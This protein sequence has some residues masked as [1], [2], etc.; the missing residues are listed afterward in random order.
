MCYSG[1][2]YVSSY[3]QQ[4]LLHLRMIERGGAKA[5]RVAAVVAT[6]VVVQKIWL[7]IGSV[8]DNGRPMGISIYV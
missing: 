8:S 5:H 4:V 3:T 6:L 7:T 1:P 2:T